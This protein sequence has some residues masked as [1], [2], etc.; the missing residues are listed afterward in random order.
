MKGV[1]ELAGLTL[2]LFCMTGF[3]DGNP[4]VGTWKLKSYVL[5]TTTGE[6]S[7]P[8]GDEV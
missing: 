3:A 8:A 6:R 4:L 1:T 2:L 7:T 5:T